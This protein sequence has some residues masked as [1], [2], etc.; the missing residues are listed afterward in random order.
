MKLNSVHLENFRLFETFDLDLDPEVTLVVGLNA[1][2][3]TALLDAL[4][5]A[6]G[7]WMRGTT[8][9]RTEDRSIWPID[10]RLVRQDGGGLPTANPS[11]PVVVRAEG[12]VG[13]RSLSWTREL[14]HSEGRTTSK[15][16][17]AIRSAAERAEKAATTSEGA[18]LPLIAYYGTGRLWVQK[19]DVRLQ[20][21]L[22]SRM[23]GYA[24]CLER[25]SNIKLFRRWMA[26]RETDRIQRIA[27]GQQE[28]GQIATVPT[29]HLDAVEAAARAC[30][31]GVKRFSYSVNYKEIRVEFDDGRLLPFSAL[32]DGQRSIVSIAVDLA[33][34]T[35]QLNPHLG[36][37]APQQTEGVV[38]IDEIELHLHPE[39]Q[40]RV[41]GDLRNAFPKVQF[42][43]STHSPQVI[44]TAQPQWLRVLHSNGVGLVGH[45]YGRD[46]N[47]IL[48][49]IM[50]VEERP[51][52]MQKRLTELELKI[53]TGDLSG[54]RLLLEELR[55][56]LGNSDRSLLALEWEL[57][58]QEADRA[59]DQ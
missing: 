20:E 50:G 9:V 15:D 29:P 47:A 8:T 13:G 57:H 38:L 33:W 46:T 55:G 59:D 21:G 3:K 44:A 14:L 4:A 19:R 32:S 7:A 53:E 6:L 41:I 52:G 43:L 37:D 25:A 30:L 5:V 51:L 48:Y 40:R 10:A 24:A 2:G 23:Q 36:K 35:A 28:G 54:A 26:W 18:A 31:R 1:C 39:W 49:D 11:F 27:A 16:A 42:V 12:L 56:N 34:R 58:D 22:G 17:K 45:S